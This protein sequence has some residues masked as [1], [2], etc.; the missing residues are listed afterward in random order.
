[1]DQRTEQIHRAAEGDVLHYQSAAPGPQYALHLVHYSANFIVRQVM[2]HTGDK[3]LVEVTVRILERSRIHD[4]KSPLWICL[5]GIC[6][7]LRGD[8]NAGVL[9]AMLQKDRGKLAC[10]AAQVEDAGT[11]SLTPCFLSKGQKLTPYDP[12]LL[13]EIELENSPEEVPESGARGQPVD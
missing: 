12:L 2:Q 9:I 5:A 10:A 8:V 13:A 7:A 11:T 4:M 6:D 1:M 3:N